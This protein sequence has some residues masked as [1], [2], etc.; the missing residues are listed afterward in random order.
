MRVRAALDLAVKH[1]R[2]LHIGAEIGPSG[3]LLD[4]VGTDWAGADDFQLLLVG[5]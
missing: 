3:D 5:S 4:A 1:A 2:H